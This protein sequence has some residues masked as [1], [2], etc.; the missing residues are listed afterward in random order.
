MKGQVCLR[1]KVN[2]F[3]SLLGISA[4]VKM[5]L[6]KIVALTPYRVTRSAPN[7][8]ECMEDCLAHL[9]ARGFRPSRIIDCG[10]HRGTFALAAHACFPAAKV[11]MVEP[12]PACRAELESLAATHG[13]TFHPYAVS[14]KAGSVPM[15]STAHAN[16]GAH[17]AWPNQQPI[18][19]E[20][21]ETV[22]ATTLD[23]L[24]VFEDQEAQS[25]LKL[26]LQGHEIFALAG[27]ARTLRNIE[28]I[29]TE[30]SFFRVAEE[31]KFSEIIA[32]FDANGFDLFDVA[33]LA[34]RHRD[35][36][37]RQGDLIVV[38]RG[39][40]LLADTAWA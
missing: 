25:L 24:I 31:A 11:D 29:I 8:F 9:A 22:K 40:P 37:L 32:F 3:M 26:D 27:A 30:V 36:R 28:V 38:R 4:T 23:A 39:S 5:A 12:Q 19:D 10:A 20:I 13:F 33:S 18:G 35:G 17:L 7:R 14:D 2:R 1:Y 16:T 6:K 15:I 21:L 34:G